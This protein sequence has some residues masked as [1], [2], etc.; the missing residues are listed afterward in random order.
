MD[1]LF[2]SEYLPEASGQDVSVYLYG[3]MQCYYPSMRD[4]T[5]A[6]ALSMT[7]E[8]VLRAFMYW[9]DK[10]LVHIVSEKPLTV[11]YQMASVPQATT[12][13]PMKYATFVR[14]LNALTAPRQYGTRELKYVFDFIENYGMEEGAV[15]ELIS[16]CMQS[17]SRNVS[18]NYINAVAQTWCENNIRTTEQA[19]EFIENYLQRRHGASEVLRRW[20]KRRKPTVDEMEAYDRW[21]NEWGFDKEAILAVCPELISVGTPTF[22]ILNDRLYELYKANK[23]KKQEIVELSSDEA[24]SREFARLVFSRLGKVEP[25]NKTNIAQ[26]NA[27]T[28][29]HKLPEQVVLLAAEACTN[30]ERP[31][32]LLKTILK[33][34]CERGIVTVAQAEKELV[35]RE[36]R[37][38]NKGRGKDDYFAYNQRK[39][40]NEDVASFFVNLDEDL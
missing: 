39:L 21:V 36:K 8:S 17:K 20:N 28:Q 27:F 40:N 10:R 24:S 18:I 38:K 1:N 37:F 6:D 25:P 16:Y 14:S 30:A 32:G 19:H 4:V 13:T 33:D 3:L 29:D 34:W 11:E 31:F 26:L 5:I 2:I 23:T 9:Q 7:P 22:S 12:E 15:L 35:E